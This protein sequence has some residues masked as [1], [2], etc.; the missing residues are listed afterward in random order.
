M[1]N[2]P[3]GW[4]CKI[5]RLHLCRGV[6]KP[7]Q[8]MSWVYNTK[9]SDGAVPVNLEL[10]I[11][12]ITPSLPSLQGL[13]WPGVVAPDRVLSMGQIEPNCVLMLNWVAWNRPVLT[14]KLR[15]YAKLISLKWNCFWHW[16][17]A[18]TL[19]WIVWIRTVWLNW[20]AWNRNVFDNWTVY[21]YWTEL[22]EE[23]LFVCFKVDLALNN[24][25]TLI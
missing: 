25:E 2:C 3:V 19:N 20:I 14:F 23:E 21:L 17:C 4:S 18:F 5:H 22:F 7:S 10:W 15:S 11:M 8:R 9:Q 24:L 12:R 1:G 13:L 6:K 16:N